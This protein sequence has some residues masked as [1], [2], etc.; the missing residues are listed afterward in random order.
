MPLKGRRR[1]IRRLEKRADEVV[2]DVTV[3]TYQQI[4]KRTPKQTGRLQ[5]SWVVSIGKPGGDHVVYTDAG[6]LQQAIQ[7]AIAIGRTAKAGDVVFITTRQAYAR[8][9]EFGDAEHKPAAMVRLA[10]AEVPLAVA[11]A[12]RKAARKPA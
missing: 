7:R 10:A 6:R 2:Q 1:L 5:T 4:L 12:V 8:A 9:V 3:W 11:R